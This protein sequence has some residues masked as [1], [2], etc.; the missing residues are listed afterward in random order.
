MPNDPDERERCPHCS[1]LVRLSA[2]PRNWDSRC[3]YCGNLVWLADGDV[4]RSVVTRITAFGV[5]VEFG[6]GVEGQ[7]HITELSDEKIQHP[8]Q[9]VMVGDQIDVKVLR[10]S[11]DDRKIGMSRRR[12][13]TL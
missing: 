10:I 12:A 9:V 3:T 2:G 6:D 1:G 13:R 5:L 11:S 8:S 7:V 4:V